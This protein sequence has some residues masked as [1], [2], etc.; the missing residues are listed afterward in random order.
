M[1][2]GDYRSSTNLSTI[3]TA[4][5]TP[6]IAGQT[7]AGVG[8]YS[9]QVGNYQQYTNVVLFYGRCTWSAHTGTG[10]MEMRT[11]PVTVAAAQC[12]QRF[13]Q[14]LTLNDGFSTYDDMSCLV[15]SSDN[16]IQFMGQQTGPV[17]Q[18]NMDSSGDVISSGGIIV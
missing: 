7:S 11:F 1:A 9:V 15:V 16:N 6:T 12:T 10:L 3:V 13:F 5:W 4:T 14:N 18:I 8:T 17:V 2:Y